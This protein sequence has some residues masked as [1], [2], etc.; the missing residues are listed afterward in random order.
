M[1]WRPNKSAQAQRTNTLTR[2]AAC[3]PRMSLTALITKEGLTKQ[4]NRDKIASI[5]T[6]RYSSKHIEPPQR[7][8]LVAEFGYR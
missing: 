4:Q 5:T 7:T 2:D 1:V 3:R 8:H 6:I